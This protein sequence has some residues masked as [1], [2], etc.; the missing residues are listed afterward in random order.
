MNP[1]AGDASPVRKT[2]VISQSD[3]IPWKGFFDL[4]GAADEL[5]LFDD[6]QY[7]RRDWR[8]RNRIKTPHGPVW[9]TIPVEV[10]GKYYQRICDT[11][12]SDP[13][14]ANA[15]W[16]Q[17]RQC[18]SR[19]AH[20]AAYREAFED[21]YLACRETSLSRINHRFLTAICS[22]LGIK[23]R[24]TWSMDYQLAEGKTER[25]ID[26]CRQARAHRYLS[27]PSARDYIEPAKFA[28]AGIEL[29]YCNYSGYPEYPQL[30]PPFVHEVSILDL[31]FNTGPDARNYMK[32][33]RA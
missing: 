16:N 6:A 1:I 21:L 22:I 3:Y 18:Y 8:N 32:T 15:H 30:Y 28:Q 2:V 11:I 24:I 13:G 4:I 27:G 19:A 9:I 10:K 25:L 29:E 33:V 12:I 23:L 31:I 7:T 26:L 17:I 14:W 5:I 20:F